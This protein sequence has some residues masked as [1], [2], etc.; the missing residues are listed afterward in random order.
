ML[1]FAQTTSLSNDENNN[2]AQ[3]QQWVDKVN[4]MRILFISPVSPMIDS[5]TQ[6][7]FEVQNLTANENI[8]DLAARVTIATNSSGQLR[9]FKYTNI[10]STNGSFAISYIFPDSGTYQ[11]LTRIDL[12]DRSSLASFNIDVPF[13]PT[14]ILNP[15]SSTF[16]PMV[17]IVALF[18][19][20]L[21]GIGILVI[22]KRKKKRKS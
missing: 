7:K 19:S 8:K 15:S 4:N 20:I 1:T 18:G 9:T 22:R 3:Q 10:S 16:Y 12:K 14:N 6:M 2:Q 13:Q 21:V 11:I 17:I 5:T